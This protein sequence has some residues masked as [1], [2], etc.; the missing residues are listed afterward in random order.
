MVIILNSVGSV[1]NDETGIVYPMFQDGTYNANDEVNGTVLQEC[2]E[3]WFDA[4]D[5]ADRKV[6]V[7]YMWLLYKHGTIFNGLPNRY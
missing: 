4:L 5:E 3:E 6:V 1:F 2:D 7:F